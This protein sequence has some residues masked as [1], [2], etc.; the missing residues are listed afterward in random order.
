MAVVAER[1]RLAALARAQ[2]RLAI[3]L[4]LPLQ[5]LDAGALMRA[6]TERL[7][8]RTPAAAPPIGFARNKLDQH[9]LA[10]ANELA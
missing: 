6:V 2:E 8:L 7:A 4:D 10:P 3:A 1:R 9:R 5:R